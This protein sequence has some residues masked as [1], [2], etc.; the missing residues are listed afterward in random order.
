MGL[1]MAAN[2]ADAGLE[3][4]AWNR[5]HE[6]TEPLAAKGV[7]RAESAADAADGCE[8]VLTILAD[9]DAVLDS[10][11][12]A[13]P[14]AAPDAL[15]LQMSTIGIEGTERCAALAAERTVGLVDAPV[16]G[17]KQPAEKGE[18][19]VLG[20]GPAEARER[21]GEAFDAVGK[22]TVWLG[23]AGAGT[24]MK[25]V[26]NAWL[27]TVVEGLAETIAFAEGVD[28][29]PES[30]LETLAGTPVDTPYAQLKGRAMIE[31]QFDPSFKLELAA[32]D[33]SLVLE[34]AARHGL[35]LPLLDVVRAQL[36][37]GATHHG[38]KDMAATFLTT[39]SD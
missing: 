2:L 38:D 14:A 37:E 6:K 1:P 16:L 19:L 28:V 32:K 8:L 27:L 9:A 13:L 11:G 15:W 34:A 21:S 20:S 35:E 36:D 22:K 30:F 25:L 4:R 29:D 12:E 3:V 33:A 31:R 7:A 5:T 17:T 23:E 24:R 10:A 18:L 39:A 26:L